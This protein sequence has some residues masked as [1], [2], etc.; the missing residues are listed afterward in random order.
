MKLS[1]RPIFI[2]SDETKQ[3]QAVLDKLEVGSIATWQQL[4][5]AAGSNVQ[6][7]RGCTI[8]ARSAL[9]KESQKVFAAVRGVGLQR[10][11]DSDVVKHEG[12]TTG[13]IKRKVNASLKRLATVKP[14]KLAVLDRQQYNVTSSTLGAISL[15]TSTASRNK[16]VQKAISN[17]NMD[18][19]ESLML[20]A[21]K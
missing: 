7:M 4:T 8:T 1:Q 6:K 11:N 14:D 9:L 19:A 18:A 21:K 13:A 12:M 3:V 5:D 2:A 20:F 17:G 10:L 16:L 15:C